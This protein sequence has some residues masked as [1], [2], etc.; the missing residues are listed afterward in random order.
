MSNGRMSNDRLTNL[1]IDSVNIQPVHVD[2]KCYSRTRSRETYLPCSRT[3]WAPTVDITRSGK[4]LRMAS[5]VS[6]ST[7]KFHYGYTH[8]PEDPVSS[9]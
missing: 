5:E 9:P 2:H 3:C 8:T 7:Y 4:R 6:S 1:L